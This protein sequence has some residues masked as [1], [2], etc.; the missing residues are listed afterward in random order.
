M[1]FSKKELK[2]LSLRAIEVERVLEENK[3]YYKELDAIIEKLV[4]GEIS[5]IQ[6]GDQLITVV[7]NFASKNTNFRVARF[8]RFSLKIDKISEKTKVSVKKQA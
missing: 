4:A 5:H 1:N 3:S 2:E 6:E 8:A 7:D